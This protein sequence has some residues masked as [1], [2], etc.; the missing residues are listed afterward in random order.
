M[1]PVSSADCLDDTCQ[2]PSVQGGIQP[3]ERGR[4]LAVPGERGKLRPLSE[5]PFR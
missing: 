3:T 4:K 2:R 5:R 1:P